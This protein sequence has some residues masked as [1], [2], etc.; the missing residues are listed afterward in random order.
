MSSAAAAVEKTATKSKVG[1]KF[2]Q[3]EGFHSFLLLLPYGLLFFTF[4]LLPIIIAIGLSFTYFD[5]INTPKFAGLTNYI[6]LFTGDE[7]FMKYVL[8]NTVLYAI[9]VGIGGYVLSFIMAWILAQVTPRAR[10]LYALAMYTPSMAGQIMIQVIWKTI[11]SGDQSGLANAW[12][13]KLGFINQPIQWL[14]S[15]DYFMQ[16]MIF[17]SLWSSMGIGFLSM[18]SGIM[19][20]DQELYEAAYVDG[21]K[22]RAQEIIYITVPSMKPQMLFGAVMSIVNAFNMGWIGVALAGA[23]PT[24]DYSGQLIANHIDDY[25]VVRYEMGYAAA[26]SVALLALVWVCSKVA[27]TLFTEKEEY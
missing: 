26:V 21:I 24:P 3:T 10:T 2:Y 22:N 9:V 14:I 18:L 13:Q 19:N 23:N 7:V 12:L 15:S 11:F 20:I 1:K 6:T 4:I 17:I 16:I 27:N 25:A 5:V 8:P